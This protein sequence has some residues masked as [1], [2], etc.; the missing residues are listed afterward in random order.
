MWGDR[1]RLSD[2]ESQALL[3]PFEMSKIDEVMKKMKSN[4][5]PGPDGFPV[6]FYKKLWP[7]FRGLIKEMLDDLQKATLDSDRIKSEVHGRS[8][9]LYRCVI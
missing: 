2:I 4:T 7:E 6:G 3:K 9:N 1:L 8:L 5:A